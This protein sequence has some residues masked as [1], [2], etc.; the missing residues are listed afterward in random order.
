M[1]LHPSIVRATAS[2]DGTLLS[3]DAPLLALQREAG[4][5]LLGPLAIPQLAA[6]VRLAARLGVTVSRPVVAA[7]ERGDIDMWVRARSDE[8]PDGRI[9]SLAVV[10]WSERPPLANAGDHS[11][12]E[13]DLAALADGWTWQ[14]DT[15]LQ[16]QMAIAGTDR[17]GALPTQPPMPGSRF[18]SYFELQSDGEGDMAILRGFT[19]RRAFRDQVATLVHLSLIHI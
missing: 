7:A 6:V 19:Q 8:G 14:I 9:V 10:D 12:R 11:R 5:D 1:T 2:A 3:A 4:S 15:Q 18:S 17:Q 16:F 13:A